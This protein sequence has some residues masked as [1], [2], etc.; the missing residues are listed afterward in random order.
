MKYLFQF[1]IIAVITAI[2]ELL[3]LLLP[4]PVPASIY[5]LVIL[6]AALCLKIIRLDQV[7]HA[8]D[9]FL[10]IMPILFVPPTVNLMNYWGILKN[11][12]AGLLITCII[13][14]MAVMG[15]T[16][17]IAQLVMKKAIRVQQPK[18]TGAAAMALQKM[19]LKPWRKP[20]SPFWN[21]K[22]YMKKRFCPRRNGN[23]RAF[24]NIL[25]L[26]PGTDI[27]FILGRL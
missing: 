2:G 21:P 15:I 9:F 20:K 17:S 26:W 16:G 27:I 11:N 10:A 18:K 12:I 5:G 3:N 1:T 8:A 24:T 13:S 22:V 19:T 25:I 23:E 14:T 6:F 4:L 7:E